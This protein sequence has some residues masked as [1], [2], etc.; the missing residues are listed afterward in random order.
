M[1]YQISIPYKIQSKPDADKLGLATLYHVCDGLQKVKDG[2]IRIVP[3]GCITDPSC[4]V[5]HYGQ[6]VFED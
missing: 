5:F 3:Y 4:M 2:M 1:S 6:A